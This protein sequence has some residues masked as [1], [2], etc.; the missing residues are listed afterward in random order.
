MASWKQ[1]A[2]IQAP[3]EDVWELLCDPARG[4][5]WDRA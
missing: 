3:V 5:D 4:P 1:Q 2:L